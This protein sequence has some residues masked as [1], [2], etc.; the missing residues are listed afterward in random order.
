M[1]RL[2]IDGR[3]VGQGHPPFV[4]AE[5]GVNHN[6][7]LELALEMIDV[8]ASCGVDAVKFQTFRASEF[9][10]DVDQTYTYR[11]Q[12]KMITESMLE[13]FQRFELPETSWVQIKRQCE[14]A[15]LIFFSTP[16]NASDLE[17]LL[18]IG[19]P[20][21][22]VGSD[23]FINLPLLR[24]CAKTGLPVILSSG[25]S[26]LSDVYHALSAVGALEGYP[27]I[28]LV[29]TSEYPT[30]PHDA[31][32]ARINALRATF[33]G[34]P[35]GFSDHTE[36]SI[37]AILATGMGACFLEKH[38]TLSHELPGPDHWFSANPD[39]LTSWVQSIRAAHLFIGSPQ[40]RPTDM[41]RTG[42]REFQ[43]RIVAARQISCGET[44]TEDAFT[45]RRVPGGRGLLPSMIELILGKPAHRAY[46]AGEPIEW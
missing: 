41:E 20:A 15:G 45:L 18:R 1:N 17:I 31:N 42:K 36:G 7:S 34:L 11:S 24:T 29:C 4:V 33:P 37:A 6:G 2:N 28:L 8:A 39:E 13:M 43:R 40:I 25:M 23:D 46:K 12:G 30:P 9:V 16:Q 26:D 21:I 3:L 19:V 38:F 22:K 35:I 27:T 14:R 5:V 44:I 32:L 10:N